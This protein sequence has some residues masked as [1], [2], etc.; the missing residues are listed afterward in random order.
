[1]A[2]LTADDLTS[3]PSLAV[4]AD[5]YGPTPTPPGFADVRTLN[6]HD[7]VP[8][9]RRVRVADAPALRKEVARLDAQRAT[10][11]DGKTQ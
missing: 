4:L 9:V 11:R 3:V 7:D 10:R 8:T 6:P 2:A 1:M 5:T